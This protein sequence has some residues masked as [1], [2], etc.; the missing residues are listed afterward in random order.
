MIDIR[1]AHARALHGL[2]ERSRGGPR[3]A[4]LTPPDAPDRDLFAHAFMTRRIDRD[5]HIFVLIGPGLETAHARQFRD[6]NL[7]SL[8]RAPDRAL[9][10]EFVEGVLALRAPARALTF[11]RRLDGAER[12]FELALW[13]LASPCGRI[14]RALGLLQPLQ[15][16][17]DPDRPVVDHRL[18]ELFPPRSDSSPPP[19]AA[20]LALALLEAAQDAFAAETSSNDC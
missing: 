13:P 3:R 11:G 14:D 5:H 2:W 15:A 4:P 20:A 9:A 6:Q 10:T 17:A 19:G 18:A 1:H 12:A 7:F 8:W 16:D